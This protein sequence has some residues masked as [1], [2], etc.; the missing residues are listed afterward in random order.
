MPTNLYRVWSENDNP[1]ARFNMPKIILNAKAPDFIL[2]DFNGNVVQLSKFRGEKNV[3]LIF[4]R[5]FT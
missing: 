2:E 4:N 1:I 3:V 5:G